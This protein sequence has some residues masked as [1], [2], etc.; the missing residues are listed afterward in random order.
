ML[1]PLARESPARQLILFGAAAA[2]EAILQTDT[3]FASGSRVRGR[4]LMIGGREICY[5]SA[6]TVAGPSGRT[7]AGLLPASV[8]NSIYFSHSK[9]YPVFQ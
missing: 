4:K 7:K 9:R 5:G 3:G 8:F 2:N 1:I 6:L